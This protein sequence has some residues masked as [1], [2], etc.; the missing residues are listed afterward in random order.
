MKLLTFF[1]ALIPTLTTSIPT[2]IT[3]THTRAVPPGCGVFIMS[4]TDN[5]RMYTYP[6]SDPEAC[7]P[8]Y[9]PNDASATFVSYQVY[10]GCACDVFF[11]AFSNEP[12]CVNQQ[13]IMYIEGPTEGDWDGLVPT[14]YRCWNT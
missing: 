10:P 12:T 11:G 6:V 4:N 13:D 1:L 2:T 9:D 3:T 8:V 7:Q 14:S 5:I